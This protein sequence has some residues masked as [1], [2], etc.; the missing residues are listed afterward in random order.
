MSFKTLFFACILLSYS[1]GF[2]QDRLEGTMDTTKQV[3]AKNNVHLELAG[4]GL[5]YSINYERSLFNLGEKTSVR[6]SIGFCLFPGL[7]KVRKSNDFLMPLSVSIQ[8][9]L[10][11]NHFISVGTGTTYYNYL[12]NDIPITNV[13]LYQQPLVAQLKPITEWFG[14]INLEYRFQKPKGGLMYKA[15]ITPLFF[16]KMQNFKGMKTAQFSANIGIGYTF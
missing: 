4:K 15:G 9:H 14:H 13:N 7:T 3:Y 10:K 11:K 12:I 8:H 5:F 1:L 16:D 6:A 2:S